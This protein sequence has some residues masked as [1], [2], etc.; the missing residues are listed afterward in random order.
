MWL[1]INL[2]DCVSSAAWV[3]GRFEATLE[4]MVALAVLMPIGTSMGGIAGSQ[5]LT[6]MIRGLALGQIQAGNVRVLLG[7]EMG[8]SALN[9]LLWATVIALLAVV[10]FGSW[11]LGGI[12]GSD[13]G[14]PVVRRPGGAGHSLADAAHGH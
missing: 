10:W 8:I 12:L 1:G 13:S 4:Q 11:G 9:G 3:I 5:T 6:L 14:Q 7:R 2:V